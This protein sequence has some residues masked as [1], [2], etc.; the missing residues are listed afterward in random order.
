MKLNMTPS[1]HTIAAYNREQDAISI[2]QAM[3]TTENHIT[4]RVWW[5]RRSQLPSSID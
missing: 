2:I 1:Y 4:I 5:R 3:V